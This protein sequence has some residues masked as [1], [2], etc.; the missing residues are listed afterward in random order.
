M[1]PL[2]RLW[3]Y[4]LR[5][6]FEVEL[7]CCGGRALLMDARTEACWYADMHHPWD[8]TGS[9]PAARVNAWLSILAARA[10]VARSDR[11]P[12]DGC[13]PRD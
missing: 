3:I 8:R 4:R 2:D 10:R 12:L 5:A 11:M 7:V 1:G 13:P 6:V 9:E